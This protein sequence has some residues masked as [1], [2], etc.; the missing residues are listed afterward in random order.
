VVIKS[1]PVEEEYLPA[2][3]LREKIEEM[4]LNGDRIKE[5]YDLSAPI[6][7]Y[8]LRRLAYYRF[9]IPLMKNRGT[10]RISEDDYNN[11]II[12]MYL[13]LKEGGRLENPALPSP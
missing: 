9:V 4:I 5:R 10:N 13:E 7:Q 8:I 1:C 12:Q 6:D 3:K 2:A 11:C